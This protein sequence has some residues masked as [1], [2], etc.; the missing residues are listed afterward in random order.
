V[1]R[2]LAL[3]VADA[4]I[5][6]WREGMDAEDWRWLVEGRIYGGDRSVRMD[7]PGPMLALLV[8]TI[9]D[10]EH[11]FEFPEDWHLWL[12]TAEELGRTD[13]LEVAREI[14]LIPEH[15]WWT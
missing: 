8:V 12:V 1:S 15:E 13:L 10:T 11:T 6:E 5:R 4:I 3:Q 2:W 14:A 9:G 7:V